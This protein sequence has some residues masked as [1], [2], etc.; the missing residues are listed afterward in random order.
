MNESEVI[1]VLWLML[2]GVLVLLM[3]GGF[4]CLESG[5]TR[6][7][8]AINVALKNAF[9]LLVVLVVFWFFGFNLMFGEHN[10]WTLSWHLIAPDFSQLSFWNAGFFFFQMTF[11]ATAA[12]IVSGA[13]AERSRFITYV[14]LTILIAG[15]IYPTIGYWAWS[16]IY[17]TSGG[18]L[19]QLGF[20]DFAG[21]TVVHGVG[22]WVALAA[23]IM[24]GP[25]QGRFKDGQVKEIPGSNVPVA[26]LGLV[27]F[28]VGW[29]GFNGGS[30]LA[31]NEQVPRI[32]INTLMAGAAGGT[33]ALLLTHLFAGGY[34]ATT[35]VINGTLAGLVAITA[36][37]HGVSTSA[38]LLIGAIGCIFMLLAE[39]L[40]LRLKLDDPIGAVPVHLVAGIWG[41]LAVALFG[42]AGQL[43]TGLSFTDQL[44]VQL[45]GIGS[46]GVFSLS[47]ALSFLW[48][49]R[50]LMPLRVSAA[51]ERQGLNVAEHGA[52]TELTDLLQAMAKQEITGDLK[53]TVHAEP[54]TEVGLIADQYNKV[55][56]KLNQM[57]TR[58]R[59]IVRDV[60][61]GVI[62]FDQEGVISSVNPSA[63]HLFDHPKDQLLGQSTALLLHSDNANLYPNVSPKIVLS[64]LAASDSAG[65]HQ[66]I[67]MKADNQPFHVEV[68][69]AASPTEEGVQYSAVIRD[70]S[71]RKR[72]EEQLHRH[73]ELAQVTLEAITEG[74]ITFDDH[75]KAIYIN[76]VAAALT[77]W[78]SK[79]AFGKPAAQI[80]RLL[81]L[82]GEVIELK[83]LC[84]RREKHALRL[85][86]KEGEPFDV[87]LTPAPLHDHSGVPVGWVFVI[88]DVTQSNR[89]QQQLSFH[90]THDPL[91]GLIN[92]RE[93]ENCLQAHILDVEQNDTE[94][95]LCYLDLDQF[96]I[97]NDTCGH[98][99]GDELLK[100]LANSL[101]PMLRQS[102][103]I[104]R[105]GG[106]EFG[107]LLSHCPLSRGQQIAEKLREAV[108]DFRFSWDSQV[109][110]VG[111]SIGIVHLIQPCGDLHT[112]LSKADTAC[113]LAKNQGR[114]RVQLHLPDS[115]EV[116][117]QTEQVQWV[118]RIQRALDEDRFRLY[119]QPIVALQDAN[120]DEAHYEILLRMQDERGGLIPPGA[121]IP[122]AERFNLMPQ[123]DLW[124]IRNTLSWLGDW[125]RSG[126]PKLQCSINLSGASIGQPECLEIIRE[127]LAKHRVPAGQ[128]CFEITETTAMAD[129][130]K[131]QH[132]IGEL[133]ALGCHFALDDFGSGL[134]SFAYLRELPV[135]FLKIDGIFIRELAKSPIDRAMVDSINTIGHVMGL[136][137][138]AEFVEDREA[139][140]VL[141]QLGVD[142]AQGYYFGRPDPL[143]KLGDVYLMPR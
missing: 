69:T 1:D 35:K 141:R 139:R 106:D 82:N 19:Q 120:P 70:I 8:N 17:N 58:T 37:V 128:V 11:C 38:A 21:S 47:L 86:K 10:G 116:K 15:F 45:I 3:Q 73:S 143:E 96:K 36:S 140:D 50:K 89:L 104:A 46:V 107:V 60:R 27:F 43:Q 115:S 142:Y 87:E 135:D 103:I 136:K 48:L 122:S 30:V 84:H 132:F 62:T 66:L 52:R 7:K 80:L 14:F 61:D 56:T 26:M 6:S 117:T 53:Q 31:F 28:I 39:Q 22:G 76:P 9:D 55:M 119:C 101:K 40:M 134:S 65:P 94:H 91:T 118:S 99:A 12:T 125:L 110:A 127:Q 64:Q 109:F 20:V 33:I 90:A 93:F 105:L 112:M 42:R 114:N 138:V 54:F 13:I 71:E 129:L 5:L 25:R 57:V 85:Q 16:G 102:D 111:V 23:I 72:M 24:I 44:Q 29:I 51:A 63:E 79:N 67:A 78:S 49:I 83:T 2:A 68:T 121:F 124:V 126:H 41:T 34:L 133:R 131:A 32:I 88:Q 4:L 81:D 130:K 77:G 95:L 74:V 113:Y 59:L 75:L 98:R 123:I 100:Q 108:Q 97:V 137:T 18:W 92:R